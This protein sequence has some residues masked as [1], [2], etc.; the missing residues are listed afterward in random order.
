VRAG[1][2]ATGKRA[3]GAIIQTANY[4]NK[5]HCRLPI[6]DL[7]ISGFRFPLLLAGPSGSDFQLAGFRFQVIDGLP[8]GYPSGPAAEPRRGISA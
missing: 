4:A 7:T 6:H 8:F 2:S 5:T 1:G 3:I